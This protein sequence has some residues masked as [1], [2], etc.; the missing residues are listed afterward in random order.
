MRDD[1]LFG[2]SWKDYFYLSNR[3]T[4]S[5]L[6]LFILIFIIETSLLIYFYF[7]PSKTEKQGGVFKENIDHFFTVDENDSAIS[8]NNS[9]TEAKPKSF[10]AKATQPSELFQFNPNNLPEEDW[11]RLGF[12]DRQIR[13]IKNYESKGGKFRSKDDVKKMYSISEKEYE[14]IEPYIIIPIPAKDTIKKK[15]HNEESDKVNK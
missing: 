12:S 13:V 8:E 5:L 2:N 6:I 15:E 1:N 11:K 10:Q 3:L 7:T 9:S 14:R 4:R